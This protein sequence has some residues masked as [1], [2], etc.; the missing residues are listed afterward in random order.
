VSESEEMTERHLKAGGRRFSGRRRNC[1]KE[2]KLPLMTVTL[3]TE[4]CFRAA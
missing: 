1:Q 2:E 4:R 3:M